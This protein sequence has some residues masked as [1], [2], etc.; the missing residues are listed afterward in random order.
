MNY[1]LQL[2]ASGVLTGMHRQDVA[3]N[4]LANVG[5][6]GFKPNIA[7]T[8][9]RD[10]V[11][12]EDGVYNLPSNDLLE[13]LGG[14]LMLAPSRI[15]FGQGALQTTGN[16]L[17]IAVQGD[18]FLM[19]RES[20]GDEGYRLRLTR[21]GRMTRDDDGRLV[22]A[23]SGLPIL[24]DS[25]KEITLQSGTVAIAND[26]TIRQAGQ[27]IARL[28]LVDVPDHSVLSKLG[29]N[30]F[31]VPNDQIT[32]RRPATGSIVQNALEQSAINEINAIESVTSASSFVRAN[33]AMVTY[34][35]RLMESAINR[36]GRVG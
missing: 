2:S 1:G 27:D 6:V 33:L 35:D 12:A 36:L 7:S 15:S 22:L 32:N 8:I 30:L 11:R 31:G 18:G 4:N 26:G 24:D 34:Q 17:D 23:S 20:A 19:V 13:A 5:T 28:A 14:G 21:D 29:D 9:Q 3:T 25:G 10:P 16:D